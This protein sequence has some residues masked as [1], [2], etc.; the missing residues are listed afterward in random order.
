MGVG[1]AGP[2]ELVVYC[3]IPLCDTSSLDVWP[4]RLGCRQ[5]TGPQSLEIGENSV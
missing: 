3:Q 2:S 5:V 1:L 4:Y